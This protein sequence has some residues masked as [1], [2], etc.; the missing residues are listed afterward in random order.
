MLLPGAMNA[1]ALRV[2]VRDC[3]APRLKRGDIVVWDNLGIHGDLESR[4]HIE[5][6][7]ATLEFLPPYSGVQ[8]HRAGLWKGED[9]AARHRRSHLAPLSPLRLPR[10]VIHRNEERSN[11][12]F[13]PPNAGL[14]VFTV[15]SASRAPSLS[16]AVR[17]L[18][19]ASRSDKMTL[20]V[21]G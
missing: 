16:A 18:S 11:S 20:G 2:W 3:L 10:K 15:R 14:A 8:P 21:R 13:H 17:P 1:L 4:G 19:C 6:R 5:A 7:G 9:A 12:T